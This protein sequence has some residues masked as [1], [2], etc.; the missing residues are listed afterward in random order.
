MKIVLLSLPIIV[1]LLHPATGQREETLLV[2]EELREVHPAYR[3]LLNF[4]ATLVERAKFNASGEIFNLHSDVATIKEQYAKSAISLE[5]EM[6]FHINGQDARVD[7][8]C[9][10]L[11]SGN[12]LNDIHLA[13]IDF[14]NC[15][16]EVDG[17]L[18]N[19]IAEFYAQL[20][21]EG[22]YINSSFYE[23]FRGEN[24][25]L[26]P[27]SIINKLK[28][29]HAEMDKLPYEL[30]EVYNALIEKFKAELKDVRGHYNQCLV[31]DNQLLVS[32]IFTLKSQF[33]II[34]G[35]VLLPNAPEIYE[36]ELQEYEP[37]VN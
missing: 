3:N 26:N 24:I 12:L 31:L 30:E 15:I 17:R 1:G 6:A 9:L 32:A 37:I 13:G 11:L 20:Q 36:I 21:G 10:D 34:C 22:A 7:A 18:Q 16:L 35:G 23:V 8:A 5:A 27:Q 29:K 14:S 4:V 25:F 2:V 33:E 28:D 19:Q